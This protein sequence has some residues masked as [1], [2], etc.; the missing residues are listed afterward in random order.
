MTETPVRPHPPVMPA[1]AL[2]RLG[3]GEVAYVRPIRSEEL[4]ALF[5]NAPAMRP[6]LDLFALFNADGSPILVTDS[7]ELAVKEALEH[8]LRPVG[9]H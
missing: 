5:P 3:G 9:L 7:R 1:D 4:T 2:R 6:G 8:D